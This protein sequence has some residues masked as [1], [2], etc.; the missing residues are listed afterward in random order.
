MG[1][2]ILIDAYLRFRRSASRYVR[3]AHLYSAVGIAL[4]RSCYGQIFGPRRHLAKFAD[5]LWRRLNAW[6]HLDP[7]LIRQSAES[8]MERRD[9]FGLVPHKCS[10]FSSTN[11][12]K[13]REQSKTSSLWRRAHATTA[14]TPSGTNDARTR[15]DLGDIV[16]CRA[17][18]PHGVPQPSIAH[19]SG[20]RPRPGHLGRVFRSLPSALAWGKI[21]TRVTKDPD[22]DQ[23]WRALLAG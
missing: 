17:S 2:I 9:A 21:G 11:S 5:S 14:V 15:G 13:S 12:Q 7:H 3:L 23:Q 16:A 10:S 1:S 22:R 19:P 8:Y 4:L 6:V 18:T 20:E